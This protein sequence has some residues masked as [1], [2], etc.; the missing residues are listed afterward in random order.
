[1]SLRSERAKDVGLRLAGM[2]AVVAAAFALRELYALVHAAPEHEASPIELLLAAAGY[3]G[4]TAGG[5]LIT[6]GP[7]IFDQVE[8][9][10][11]RARSLNSLYPE[12][13]HCVRG[14]GRRP[15]PLSSVF[16]GQ[17]GE[18]TLLSQDAG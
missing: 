14:P 5:V 8:V 4:T 1:M 11:L 18:R 3:L 9:P 7:H 17:H 2:L 12:K 15:M 13:H 16:F 6:L 10:R